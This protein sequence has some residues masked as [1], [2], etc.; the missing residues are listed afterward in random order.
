MTDT[1]TVQVSVQQKLMDVMAQ[2]FLAA[3]PSPQQQH[4]LS[5]PFAS[6][7]IPPSI[8]VPSLH[9]HQTRWVPAAQAIF[10]TES[11]PPWTIIAANDLACLLFGV[12]TAEVRKM[13]ILEVV[14]EER[15]AWLVRKLQKGIHEDVGDGSES[16]ISQ[17]TPIVQTP[18]LLGARAG[19]ITAKLL[20][21]PNSR[22]QTPK[23]G[24]RPATIHNG[25]PKPP[26]PGHAHGT[27]GKT[28]GVLLCGDVVPIQV[29]VDQ[30]CRFVRV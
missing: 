30:Y 24:R 17:P 14:Q 2:P 25:D 23:T 11:K 21:K 5:L 1:D 20:S 29:S 3:D 27:N 12:T 7:T 4:R 15:R 22:S 8:A 19:G 13:G 10:T 9:G 18:S 26:K 6:S 16:E 28:R